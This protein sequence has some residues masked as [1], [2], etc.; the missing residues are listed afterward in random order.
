M[1]KRYL[2]AGLS[3]VVAGVVATKLL[4]RPRDVIW[5]DSIDLISHPEYS[6]FTQVD[7]VRVHYQD[8]GDE[9]APVLI[10]IHGFISTTLVWSEVFLPLA[11]AGFRVIAIDLPG[12]GYSEKPSHARYT[13]DEQAHAVVSVMNQLGINTATIIGASYG[14]AIAA[15][16]ALDYP[17]RVDR[18]VLVGTVSSDE[19]KKKLLLRILQI[20]IIGDITTPLYLGSRWT[21]RKRMEDMYRRFGKPVDERML[22]ARHHVLATSNMQRAMIRTVRRWKADR[23]QRQASLIAA[24]TLLVWGEDDRHI[25]ISGALLLRD[26]IPDSRLVLFKNCGHLPPTEYPEKFV[27]L[28]AEFCTETNTR[29]QEISASGFEERKKSESRL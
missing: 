15:T 26:A 16:I 5:P 14:G 24:P 8:A 12:Y 4:S 11:D 18:L 13:I 3:G 6:W 23:I 21:L 19:P 25:P 7:G 9:N 27:E 2:F 20:P 29:T 1:R 10:L 28:V 17:E 22:A